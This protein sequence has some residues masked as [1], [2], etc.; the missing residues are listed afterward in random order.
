MH[1]EEPLVLVHPDLHSPGRVDPVG[2]LVAGES[3]EEIKIRKIHPLSTH[4]VFFL[5]F[6]FY[7]TKVVAVYSTTF[8][9]SCHYELLW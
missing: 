8:F 3:G 4:S 5:F 9:S 1:V 7:I 6:H 2:V